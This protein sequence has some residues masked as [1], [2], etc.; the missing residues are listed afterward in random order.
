MI[1]FKS[2]RLRDKL[3]SINLTEIE[4][5]ESTLAIRIKSWPDI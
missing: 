3:F 1:T 4:Y 5:I 2:N